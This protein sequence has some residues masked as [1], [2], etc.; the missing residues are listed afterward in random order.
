M[1]KRMTAEMGPCFSEKAA[2][3]APQGIC[4]NPGTGF[5]FDPG[6]AEFTGE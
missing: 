4:E 2:I 6:L 3:L 1:G 5:G